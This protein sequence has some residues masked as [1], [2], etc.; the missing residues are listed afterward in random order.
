MSGGDGTPRPVPPDAT[1]PLRD[2][3]TGE[4]VAAAER[5]LTAPQAERLDQIQHQL[6]GLDA[7]G[8]SGVLK[9]L[10]FSPDQNAPAEAAVAAAAKSA[11]PTYP[12][13]T[14]SADASAAAAETSRVAALVRQAAGVAAV[15]AML[16]DDQKRGADRVYG[17]PVALAKFG[18]AAGPGD[19][20]S[21]RDREAWSPA[22]AWRQ[23]ARL[24]VAG[25]P[26]DARA[27]YEE[28]L[29]LKAD[30]AAT[31]SEL[32]RLLATCPDDAVRDGKRA[33]SLAE[34]A[35]DQAGHKAPFYEDTLAAA[36]AE[37][38]RFDDAVKA[39]ERAAVLFRSLATT[40]PAGPLGY[41]P[42]SARVTQEYADRLKLYRDKKP[43]RTSPPA[44]R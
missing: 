38:G 27:A 3:V 41:S 24:A 42:F 10:K 44:G 34:A 16:R 17:A 12:K 40:G 33:V 36:Y 15:R 13:P 28:S 35:C 32:V 26:A 21:V 23:A 30:D 6:A 20:Y 18:P 25:K 9:E 19:T 22:R 11:P 14:D 37:A 7:L 5:L 8:G 1:F 4:A 43:F 29:R 2:R 39:Q 31:Q